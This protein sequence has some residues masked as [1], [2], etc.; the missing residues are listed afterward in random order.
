VGRA[1]VILRIDPPAMDSGQ[2]PLTGFVMDDDRL[3]PRVWGVLLSASVLER[4]FD[5]T[6]PL[7]EERYWG[8]LAVDRRDDP[9]FA[10]LWPLPDPPAAVSER[11]ASAGI[12]TVLMTTLST[13]TDAHARTPFS[14]RTPVFVMVDLPALPFLRGLQSEHGSVRWV[15]AHSDGDVILHLVLLALDGPD[16]L[17]FFIVRSEHTVKATTEW[18]RREPEFVHDPSLGLEVDAHLNALAQ[19][20]AGTFWAFDSTREIHAAR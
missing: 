2:H 4:Q 5:L 9:P 17:H 6:G 3:G 15:H 11:F 18:L 20:L 8:L 12:E 16:P 7:D 14:P 1:P 10:R 19:H 13:L